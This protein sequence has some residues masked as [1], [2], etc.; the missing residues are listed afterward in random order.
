[1]SSLGNNIYALKVTQQKLQEKYGN[2]MKLITRD[3]KSNIILLERV[4]DIFSEQWYNERKTNIS[5]ESERVI[6]TA[7]K[8]NEHESDTYAVADDIMSEANNTVPHFLEVFL[9]ELVKS[10]IKQKSSSEAICS[11]TRP[12]SLM[13]LQFWLA[14]AVDNHLAS[15]W[16]N[17][18]LYKLGF[19]VSYFEVRTLQNKHLEVILKA[20]VIFSAGGYYFPIKNDTFNI[21]NHFHFRFVSTRLLSH[22]MFE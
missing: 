2:S 4:A 19:A 20:L 1:M 12:R 15:K 10:P 7:A 13:L 21:A 3:G 18:L 11:A 5:N 14:I 22:K 17:N 9:K 16:L 8:L 6:R